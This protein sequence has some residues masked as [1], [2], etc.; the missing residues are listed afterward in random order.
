MPHVHFH[1]LP[2]KLQGDRFAAN[3]DEVYPALERSENELPAALESSNSQQALGPQPTEKRGVVGNA[4]PLRMD[5]D[6]D[7]KP[8]TLEEMIQEAEWLKTFF[9]EAEETQ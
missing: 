5:A 4:E 2:R 6:E 7:R 8:R 3:N 9:E 1:L